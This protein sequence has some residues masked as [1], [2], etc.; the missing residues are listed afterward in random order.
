[1]PLSSLMSIDSA[2]DR[3]QQE[4]DPNEL[5]VVCSIEGPGSPSAMG[6]QRHIE[7]HSSSAL[8]DS[9]GKKT[10]Q[11]DVSWV[12]R[13]PSAHWTGP[14]GLHSLLCGDT[15]TH[16]PA[17]AIGGVAA[18]RSQAPLGGIGIGGSQPMGFGMV[19]VWGSHSDGILVE[20]HISSAF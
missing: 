9:T 19:C 17:A 3:C 8:H 1:M 4:W 2:F 5:V 11:P 16:S 7:L 13:P 6:S 15:W 12:P 18:G 14:K 10:L 20:P